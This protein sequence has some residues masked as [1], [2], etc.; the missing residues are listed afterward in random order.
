MRAHGLCRSKV[1]PRGVRM[2]QRYWRPRRL[3]VPRP[4]VPN[5]WRWLYWVWVVGEEVRE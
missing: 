3:T 2:W 4:G 1:G 5:I